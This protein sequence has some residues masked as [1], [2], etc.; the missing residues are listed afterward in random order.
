MNT[1]SFVTPASVRWCQD[2][3]RVLV[4]DE[5]TRL[6]VSLTGLEAAVWKWFSLSY[7]Y[8]DVLNFTRVFLNLPGEDSEI[9]L[10]QI[11]TQWVELGFLAPEVEE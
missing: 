8:R 9:Q 2:S 1:G 3:T 6:T 10:R 4:I 7:E 11:I 5:S